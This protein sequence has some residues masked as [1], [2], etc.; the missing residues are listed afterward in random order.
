MLIQVE[1][2]ELDDASLTAIYPPSKLEDNRYYNDYQPL[3][4][5]YFDREYR[6]YADFEDYQRLLLYDNVGS[7]LLH[8]T[9]SL[10][11]CSIIL[12]SLV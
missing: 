8:A 5:W 9:I 10:A 1:H 2:R 12:Y 4:E 7:P 3:I 11:Q 6:T